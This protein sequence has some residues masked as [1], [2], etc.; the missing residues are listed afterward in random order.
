MTLFAGVDGGQSSTIALIADEHGVVLGRGIGGPSDHIGQSPDSRRLAGA[1]ED[2]VGAALRSAGLSGDSEFGAVVA[3]ISGFEGKIHGVA[4]RVRSTRVRFVHDAPIAHAGAFALGAGIVVIAGTGSV[5]YGSDGRA[6]AVTIGGWGF[7]FG[8][9][10]SAF[11][12]A[13]RGVARAMQ[14]EDD[15]H[16]NALGDAARVR[17]KMPALR[18][19]ARAFYLEKIDRAEFA[20]F[21]TEVMRLADDHH[22]DAQDVLDHAARALMRLAWTCAARLDLLERRCEVAL[23]GG[24]FANE[25]FR[26]AVAAGIAESLPNAKVVRPRYDPAEGALLLAYKEAGIPEP[27]PLVAPAR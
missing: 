20:G 27:P 23:A 14:A 21:A 16:A 25:R 10:G 2:A 8:D 5:A 17:F 18:E 6:G 24:L 19:L 22:P 13:R 1:I 11:D 15:G 7:L 9:E 26:S 3:G 4:P 12:I